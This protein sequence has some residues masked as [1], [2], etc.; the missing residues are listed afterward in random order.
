MAI[1]LLY[2]TN[3]IEIAHAADAAG[4]DEIFIDL[5]I[6]GKKQRQS[7]R[8]TVISHHKVD[9]VTRIKEVLHSSS[10]LV[11]CNPYGSWS[12]KEI[13]EIVNKGADLIM[14]PFFKTKHEVKGFLDCVA[15][16]TESCLLVE[17]IEAIA[18]LDSILDLDRVRRI[19]IGLNDLH[20]AKKTKFM[21]EPFMNGTL[22]NIA[23]KANQR[24]ISFGI[25]GMAQIG[26]HLKPSPQS[27]LAEHRRL[28][29]TAVIL[30]RS[31]IN[32]SEEESVDDIYEK[33][34]T[35]IASV[36]AWEKE[37]DSWSPEMFEENRVSLS[38][39]VIK[40]VKNLSAG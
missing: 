8:N 13:T 4:V 28:G 33:F 9:D 26:S 34:F 39:E 15:D 30:S 20:I 1:K 14:L 17:T 16:R 35:R 18:D 7:G 27:L 6:R 3:D 37:L 22:E 2:I 29:S 12:A 40:I 23:L 19:H 10:L 21:F 38:D 24:G 32:F 5:E 31:F 36:R 25:G 11:R